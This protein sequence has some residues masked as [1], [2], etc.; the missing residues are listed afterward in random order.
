MPPITP[1]NLPEWV[2]RRMALW[3][4]GLLSLALLLLATAFVWIEYRQRLAT[5]IE[6]NELYARTLEGHLSL[7]LT[8]VN[9]TLQSL[10]RSMEGGQLAPGSEAM[11]GLLSQS[12]AAMPYVRSFSLLDSKGLIL[13][14][15]S[16]SNIGRRLPLKL[17]QNREDVPPE[18]LGH[19]LAG[20]EL[21]D[22]TQPSRGKPT[23]ERA[24][25]QFL[26]PLTLPEATPQ[27]PRYWVATL[28]PDY[29]ANFF[30]IQLGDNEHRAALYSMNGELITANEALALRPGSHA[31]EHIVFKQFLPAHERG[32]FSAIGLDQQP[33]L[34]SFR[35]T[36]DHALALII[37]LPQSSVWGHMQEIAQAVAMILLIGLAVMGAL[38]AMAW[39]ALSAYDTARIALE[40]ALAELATK[41]REQRLLIANVQELMFHTDAQGVLQF[42]N[43]PEFLGCSSAEALLGRPFESLV[44]PADQARAR[45][46][47]RSTAGFLN[48]PVT[49]R[50]API[51][52][53]KRV[54]EVSVTPI[55]REED[56]LLGFVGFALDVTEREDA[57]LRLQAQLEFTARLID[58]C[59]I[60]IFAKDL[61]LR[62]VM[63]NQAW[64]DMTGVEKNLALGRKL[65]ELRP[66]AQADPV[67]ARDELLLSRG[68]SEH[69]EVQ[70]RGRNFLTHRAVYLDASGKPAG[71]LGSAIDISRFV[72][73][74]RQIAEA[75]DAAEHA[76]RVKTEFVA[77]MSHELRTPLQSIIGF[78]ELGIGRSGEQT[79]L[80]DMFARIHASGQ[81]ML[82][83]VNNLLDLSKLESTIGNLQLSRQ[84]LV[85]W[86]KSLV[87]E[88]QATADRQNIQLDLQ[89]KAPSLMAKVDGSRIQQALRNVLDNALRFAPADSAIKIQ[90][91]RDADALCINV[92]DQGPGIPVAELE[93]IFEP[94]HQASTPRSKALTGADSTARTSFISGQETTGLGLAVCRNIMIAH[95]G[96]VSAHNH[97]QGGALF[98]LRLP[99]A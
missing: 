17:L 11:N 83:L 14:S 39:R 99:A 61:A 79:R 93:Q 24:S 88:L 57:R 52:G 48:L 63:V 46:L 78:S 42:I 8:T 38:G 55:K 6:H 47:Y 87:E 69:L 75:R 12:L 32:N 9:M 86:V 77:N 85:P 18:G 37:E 72:E 51:N 40:A 82:E 81:R 3:G 5:E 41:E 71:V 19:L 27:G 35:L 25:Q 89:V 65:S 73:A 13:A 21:S 62:F 50:L 22:L 76:N 59:P 10:P 74:E 91:F 15:S 43:H 66:A 68:G 53:R 31:N 16:A 70:E 20:R 33:A 84:D 30:T 97:P 56:M 95:G 54:L 2:N 7:T 4:S 1:H 94:F 80:Q 45:G 90:L 29:F 44:D 49:L 98:E 36:R 96:S 26:L 60:P 23:L 28:N 64:T 92:H 58:V 67:E 34:G